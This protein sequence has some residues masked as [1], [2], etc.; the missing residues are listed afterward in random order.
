MQKNDSF[1][2][3]LPFKS[4]HM[5]FFFWYARVCVHMCWVWLSQ[6]SSAL[7]G[8]PCFRFFCIRLWFAFIDK[9]LVGWTVVCKCVCFQFIRNIS[10]GRG[11]SHMA[12]GRV[13]SN[14]ILFLRLL[15]CLPGITAEHSWDT[16]FEK[17]CIQNVCFCVGYESVA[18][19]VQ[20]SFVVYPAI[21]RI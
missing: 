13:P 17:T 5:S 19:N 2:R 20:S 8:V 14:G 6:R 3:D 10:T 9:F 1:C 11:P 4:R 21:L 7:A 12:A 18:G 16:H 15:L